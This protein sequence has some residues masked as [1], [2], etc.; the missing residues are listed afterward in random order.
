MIKYIP[1]TIAIAM[2]TASCSPTIE[3]NSTTINDKPTSHSCVAGFVEDS[4]GYGTLDIFADTEFST[5]VQSISDVSV[6]VAEEIT[7]QLGVC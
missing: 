2:L 3:N 6:K 4:P 7:E 1:W 5:K